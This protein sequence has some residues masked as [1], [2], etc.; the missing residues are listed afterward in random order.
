MILNKF[1]MNVLL[2]VTFIVLTSVILGI[3]IQHLDDGYLFTLV[4]TIF[5][6]MLQGGMLLKQVN[7]TNT[8]LEKFLSSIQ[9]Q[10]TS[11]RFAEN[12][13]DKSF[14]KLYQKMNDVNTIIQKVK[15]E[16][17][18][19]RHFLQK[20][21]D[22]VDIGLLSFHPDGTI[23]F[24]NRAAK[25]HFKVQKHGQL[26]SI[27]KENEEVTGILKT[28]KPG[29]EILYKM[30][31]DNLHQSILVRAAELTF[32]RNVIKLVSFEN[33]TNEL[34]RKELDSWRKLIR[35]L[36]HEIM[37]SISPVTSLTSVIS[38]YFKEREN[39]KPVQPE[40]I[41]PRII[42]KTLSGLSTIEETGK[43][44]LE[45]VDKYRSLTLLPE[46]CLSTFSVASLFQK[47]KLLM[48]T[49]LSD[50]IKIVTKVCPGDI[51]M[52]ADYGQVEQVLINLIKNAAEA[53]GDNQTGT[54]SL[55]AFSVNR[56]IKVIVED[57]GPGI[58]DDQSEDIFVP[59]Y[60][61]KEKGS[62]I[63]LSLSKQIMQNH[64][65]S[66][67]VS[68]ASGGGAKFTLNFQ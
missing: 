11:I 64:K 16:N 29:Q 47:C 49:E 2:R 24:V 19:T 12:I 8:D 13:G 14:C 48:Q 54:I 6:I 5:L 39:E 28:I 37:N 62:G 56:A 66:I 58:P 53:I 59:F 31:T 15:F 60:T 10:D 46:P 42:D 27:G 63:G 32:E 57:D 17:E 1:F 55:K 45:F 7:K 51:S 35:V 33:I 50:N 67:L 3:V 34:D 20:V 25:R 36:T 43:G 21:V 40:T 41:T 68:P 26:S 52:V 22:H 30:K 9:D 23:E 18:R 61:T 44:L 65:G 4:G 38:G